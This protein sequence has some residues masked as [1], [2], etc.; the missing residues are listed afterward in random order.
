M[1][2]YFYK[3]LF[4]SIGRYVTFSQ[5]VTFSQ[6][7]HLIYKYVCNNKSYFLS[8]KLTIVSESYLLTKK[9]IFHKKFCEFLSS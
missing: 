1:F 9:S 4:F 8:N 7:L 3:T 2:T 6:N 5:D